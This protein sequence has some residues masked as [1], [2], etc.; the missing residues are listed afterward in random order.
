MTTSPLEGDR[1]EYRSA[2]DWSTVPNV[3]RSLGVEGKPK[4]VQR[5]AIRKVWA[6]P[7]T[8]TLLRKIERNLRNAGLL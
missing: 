2:G 4:E 3:L 6:I 8:R 5:D 7:S 1:P